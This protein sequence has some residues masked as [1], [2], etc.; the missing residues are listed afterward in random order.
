MT[1]VCLVYSPQYP[2][3]ITNSSEIRVASYGFGGFGAPRW[4]LL[5]LVLGRARFLPNS[6]SLATGLFALCF[7]TPDQTLSVYLAV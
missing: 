7:V 2:K 1:I 3:L 5:L 4:P 6:I